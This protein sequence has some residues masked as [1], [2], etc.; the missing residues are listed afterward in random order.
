MVDF[1]KN[2]AAD[3]ATVVCAWVSSLSAIWATEV[4]LQWIVAAML[5]RDDFR[6]ACSLS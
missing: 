5:E 3:R 2:K 6:S 1:E 4:G